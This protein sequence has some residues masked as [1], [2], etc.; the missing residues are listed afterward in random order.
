MRARLAVASASVGVMLASFL[1]L[2]DWLGSSL[3]CTAAL[4]SEWY[5][6]GPLTRLAGVPLAAFGLGVWVALIIALTRQPSATVAPRIAWAF[7]GA[8]FALQVVG[9][10]A[11]GSFC[12]WCVAHALAAS[13]FAW[14]VGSAPAFNPYDMA[15]FPALAGVV[16]ASL[17]WANAGPRRIENLS[18]YPLARLEA[19]AQKLGHRNSGQEPLIAILDFN[20][21][22]CVEWAKNAEPYQAGTGKPLWLIWGRSAPV[23]EGTIDANERAEDTAGDQAVF[24]RFLASGGSSRQSAPATETE[25][26]ARR[27]VF[28]ELRIDQVPRFFWGRRRQMLGGSAALEWLREAAS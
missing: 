10:A 19:A 1:T 15:F 22:H 3:G 16:A 25:R 11:S 27:R 7:A 2:R 20:C 24:R 13:V 23:P 6:D 17:T 21:G 12:A 26:G 5:S 9:F 14:T 4:C 18:T 8:S 28:E